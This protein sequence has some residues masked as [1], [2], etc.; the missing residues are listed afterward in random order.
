MTY[1]RARNGVNIAAKEQEVYHDVHN[2]EGCDGVIAV[3]SAWQ[4]HGGSQT[5]GRKWPKHS[6]H[7]FEKAVARKSGR[8]Q[9]D[10]LFKGAENGGNAYLEEDPVLP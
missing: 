3:D 8:T 10:T 1:A 7:A 4:A 6:Q 2:L 5:R 9:P